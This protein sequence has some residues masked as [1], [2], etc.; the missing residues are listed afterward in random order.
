MEN[1]RIVQ[2]CVGIFVLQIDD[3][4]KPGR[5]IKVK[6]RQNVQGDAYL[7]KAPWLIHNNGLHGE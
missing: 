5:A 3:F 1:Q 2:S 7:I 4:L 6:S